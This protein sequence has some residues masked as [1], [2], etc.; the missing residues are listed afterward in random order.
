[1]SVCIGGS[2]HG[3]VHGKMSAEWSKS[4]KTAT[5]KRR[6]PFLKSIAVVAAHIGFIGL[7]FGG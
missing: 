6:K 4:A 7:P 2:Y 3:L 5:N 1:M